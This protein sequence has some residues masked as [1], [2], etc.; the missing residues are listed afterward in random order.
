MLEHKKIHDLNDFFLELGKRPEKAVYFY[1]IN[2]FNE[3]IEAFV[4]KYYEA[5]RISGV[6]IEEKI[7]NPDKNNLAYYQEMMGMDFYV[8]AS[9]IS[10]RLKIWLPRIN[11]FQREVMSAAMY[12]T[13]ILLRKSG[14]NDNILKNAYIKM[15]C[16]LYYKF[17]RIVNRL[18]TE[19]VPK[20]LYQGEISSYELMLISVL[21][22]VG[23]DVVLLQY[24]GDSSYLALDANSERSDVLELSN[25]KPFPPHF[26]I[27]W[28]RQE[29]EKELKYEKLYGKK[30]QILNCTNV[31]ISG[32]GFEDIKKPVLQRG[33][34][35][36]L[37]YNCFIRIN[38][39]EDKVTYIND[40]YQF[41]LE[42]RNTKRRIVIAEGCIPPPSVDEINSLKRGIYTSQEQMLTDIIK[43]IDFKA[44]LEL[45]QLMIKAFLDEMLA[46]SK[47]EGM[48][49]NKLTSKAVYIICWLRRYQNQLFANW[50]MPEISCFIYL[51]GCQNENE[52]MFLRVLSKLP[53][54][55]LIL[56]PN[57]NT[58]C[59][60][61]D[62]FLYEIN[63]TESLVV[64][65][66]PQETNSVHFGTV[67]YHAER[68]LDTLLYQDTG[69]YRNRQYAK[70]NAITLQ[71]MYE[72][73]KILWNQE[74][75]YR[76][77]FSTTES[78]VNM[79]V[80]FAKISG[81]KDK[82]VSQY[83]AEIKGL[84]TQNTYLIKDAPFIQQAAPSPVKPY[85]VEFFKNGRLQ[86]KKILEHE[87]YQYGFL[88]EEIQEHILDKLQLLIDS[89]LIKGTFENGT[90][91]T[92]IS[93]VLNL[94]KDI[95][96][97]IQNFDFTKENPKL[98][99][100][101]TT[102]RIISLE[103]SIMTAFLNLVGFD[104]VFF[105]PT[106]YQSIEKYFN[107]KAF[108]EHQAGEYVYDLQM[109]DLAS[110]SVQTRITWRDRIF[111]RK[112]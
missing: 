63:Y 86:R 100:V 97:L 81:V 69:M 22:K 73:V 88:R 65:K 44:N 62:N 9:F 34:D 103:D 37:F 61:T 64:D 38:G 17:E 93:N 51:G 110:I 108:E 54:D 92:I 80:I 78:F 72:E 30:P 36:G 15:M 33:N 28:I 46:E 10:E 31:W 35:S 45:Q 25:M 96:R 59:C 32:T 27:K 85:A 43:N 67:A 6:I 77:N 47:K 84:A 13:L 52:A 8:D 53:S 12:D 57:L 74:L 48:N 95:I 82:Q 16:W 55:I 79:P 42:L 39:V 105:V 14:K 98:I 56:K 70:A 1:R 109:P 83:W 49:L 107:N 71:T 24:N 29:L 5:A 90:E 99:Y 58:G 41:A 19:N 102:E 11:D 91:Y 60:L 40:L 87:C 112:K 106:G 101:N 94:P 26:N 2:G 111:R 3:K 76:P 20:I 50:K 68:E 23:C 21:S 7:Q 75:R 66:F 4:Q 18:G 89:K 104:I